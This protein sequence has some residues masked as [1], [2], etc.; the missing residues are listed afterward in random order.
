MLDIAFHLS[1]LMNGHREYADL[2]LGVR[3][4]HLLKFLVFTQSLPFAYQTFAF[5]KMEF[6]GADKLLVRMKRDITSFYSITL[7]SSRRSIKSKYITMT[8][9]RL[10]AK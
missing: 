10:S 5:K 4:R 6:D 1:P 7:N 9:S 3:K 2:D 8:A